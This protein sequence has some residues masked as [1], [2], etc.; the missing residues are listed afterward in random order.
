MVT[1]RAIR[2]EAPPVFFPVVLVWSLSHVQPS[3]E[4]V[5]CSLPGFSVHGISQARILE[6]ITLSFSRDPSNPEINPVSPKSP[7][8]AG[9]FFTAEPPGK[10]HSCSVQFCLVPQSCLTLCDPMDC[11]T[12]GLPVHH[13]LPDL[14]QAHVH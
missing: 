13:Q 6:W 5:D 10:P 4:P 9:G 2:T 8:L 12:P 14:A 11:S 7:A 3:A 1:P